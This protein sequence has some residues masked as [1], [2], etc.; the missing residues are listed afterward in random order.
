METVKL[1]S[2]NQKPTLKQAS[3]HMN[4]SLGT[5]ILQMQ[6]EPRPCFTPT[7][8]EDIRAFHTYMSQSIDL[9]QQTK[10]YSDWKYIVL[11]SGDE[12][13]FNLGG[14]LALFVELIEQRDRN[15]LMDYATACIDG[16]YGFHTHLGQ[17]V[18]SIALVEGN[19]QGGGFE[20]ALS[21]NVIIAERG[22]HLGF[23]EVLFNMFPG[24]GAYSFLSRRVGSSLAERLIYSGDL[25]TAETL[26]DLGVIDILADEGAG[27]QALTNYIRTAQRRT[28]AL[29]LIRHVRQTYHT[30]PYE[31]LLGITTQWVDAALNLQRNEIGIMQRLVRAQNKRAA[32]L[33]ESHQKELRQ[34]T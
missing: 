23:P 7:L 33:A 4:A 32:K 34:A 28:N 31:E 13:T 21:C 24:M 22:T 10:G 14:D 15:K 16:A 30:V 20:A 5:A 17:P 11:A 1:A 12:Q 27:H 19:A 8:L 25:Y 3:L 26:Y 9:D 29:K 18:T 6:P 2:I